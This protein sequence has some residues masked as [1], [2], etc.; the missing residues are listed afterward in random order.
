M[1]TSFLV[2]LIELYL[3]SLLVIIGIE[4]AC[5]CFQQLY[6]DLSQVSIPSSGHILIHASP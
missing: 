4:I 2:I 3:Y 6:L 1:P 5:Q